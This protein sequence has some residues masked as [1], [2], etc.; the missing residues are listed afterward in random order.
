MT[1]GG[2]TIGPGAPTCA[3]ELQIGL[4][5]SVTLSEDDFFL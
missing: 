1:A 4:T 3:P 5:G 2:N